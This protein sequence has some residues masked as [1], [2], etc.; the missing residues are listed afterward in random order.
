[1]SNSESGLMMEDRKKSDLHMMFSFA[2]LNGPSPEAHFIPWQ[3]E[4]VLAKTI[5]IY[6]TT[7]ELIFSDVFAIGCELILVGILMKI[8]RGFLQN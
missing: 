6:Y 3:I 7:L 5:N 1:M 2:V 4:E 8:S